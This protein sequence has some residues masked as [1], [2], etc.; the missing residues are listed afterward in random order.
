MG[1]SLGRTEATGYGLIY[2]VREA[3][4]VLGLKIEETSASIQGFGNVAQYAVE[5]YKELGGTVVAISCWDNKDQCSYTFRNPNG[6][7]IKALMASTDA[8]GSIDKEKAK[9]L[10]C[11]ILDG[12]AWLVQEVDLL[13]PCAIENQITAENVNKIS[14]KVKLIAEGS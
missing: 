2:T 5:L 10:G 3:L 13:F 1:G 4:K 7:D 6:L 8:F 11:E 9:E 12:D 14:P